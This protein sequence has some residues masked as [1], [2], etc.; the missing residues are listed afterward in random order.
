MTLLTDIFKDELIPKLNSEL[1]ESFGKTVYFEAGHYEELT[2]RIDKKKNNVNLQRVYPLVWLVMDYTQEENIG[3]YSIPRLR[4][5]I[6][7]KSDG[8]TSTLQRIEAVFKPTLIPIWETLRKVMESNF[9]LN[10]Q[11]LTGFDL[12]LHPYAQGLAKNA[13]LFN[14]TVDSIEVSNISLMI[15]NKI[16]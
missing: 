14:D 12:I 4:L 2:A 13:N 11:T 3:G 10:A 5:F 16:C 9:S 1:G 6:V 7:E 8:Y 15:T